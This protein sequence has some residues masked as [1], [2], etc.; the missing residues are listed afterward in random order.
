[1]HHSKNCVL[2]SQMGQTLP[3]RDFCGTAA[4]P[5]KPDIA[6]RGWHGRKVPTCDMKEAAN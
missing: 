6:R 1:V 2:M 5:L 4:L 3:S